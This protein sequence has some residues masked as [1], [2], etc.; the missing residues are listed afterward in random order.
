MNAIIFGANGQDGFYLNELCK[1]KGINPIGLSRSGDWMRGDISNYEQVEHFIKEYKPTYVFHLAAK[2]TTR[3]DALFENHAAIS[4][5]TLN[6]LE[7]VY[8]YSSN[9]KVFITGSGVQFYN[10]GNPISEDTPFEASSTYAIARIQSVYAARY[11]RS[12]GIKAYV[13]Y[14]FHHE[15]PL[16]KPTHVSQ[17]VVLAAKRIV[18]GADEKL[19]MGDI[20]VEKEWTFAG[21]VAQGII[22]L[23]EQENVFEAVIGSGKI[24]TIKDWIE[25]CFSI[26]GL[27][28]RRYVEQT[29]NFQTE[30]KRL[31]S[32][33]ALMH[34][35][36]WRPNIDLQQLAAMMIEAR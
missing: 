8:K 14:L 23:V 12:L 21:D 5:G 13:G 28:W 4:T 22:T 26:L 27:D 16:R 31:V 35:L 6:I 9:S 32:N 3:H 36:H 15:S 17:K 1:A 10:D 30:Y 33:P 25:V 34:S 2:S 24:H 18:E 20:S 19:Q 11:Y 7:A 29:E